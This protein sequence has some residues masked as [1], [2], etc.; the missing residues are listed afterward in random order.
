MTIEI[1]WSV[2]DYLC[3]TWCTCTCTDWPLRA[4]TTYL[5]WL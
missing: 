5:L 3:C 1:S 4:E 2:P